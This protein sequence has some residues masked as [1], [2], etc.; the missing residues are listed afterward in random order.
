MKALKLILAA[1]ITA[2]IVY[3]SAQAQEITF[4]LRSGRSAVCEPSKY[5]IETTAAV[6]QEQA[7]FQELRNTLK[8]ARPK[9]FRVYDIYVVTSKG[10]YYANYSFQKRLEKL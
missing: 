10:T 6:G 9:G 1:L 2:T 4:K 8:A 7:A 5:T 3:H